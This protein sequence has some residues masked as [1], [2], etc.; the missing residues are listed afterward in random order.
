MSTLDYMDYWL[1]TIHAQISDNTRSQVDNTRLSPP[2]FIVGTH[3]NS[4]A[5]D[6]EIQEMMV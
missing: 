1:K 2:V 4:L 3:R 6:Q 5:S